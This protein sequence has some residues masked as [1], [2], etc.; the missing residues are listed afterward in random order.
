M[1]ET[2][3]QGLA[4]FGMIALLC[5]VV[6]ESLK[7]VF[8]AESIPPWADR[9]GVMTLAIFVCWGTGSDLFAHFK[10]LLPYGTGP[11]FTGIIC[12]RGANFIHDRFG[13][14]TKSIFKEGA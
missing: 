2:V 7:L 14:E 6:W 1:A 13:G 9:L 3:L 11:V 4:V 8:P 10:I 12:S 5:E